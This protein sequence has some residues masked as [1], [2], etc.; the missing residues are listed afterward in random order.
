MNEVAVEIKCKFSLTRYNNKKTYIKIA[1]RVN[2]ITRL[3]TLHNIDITLNSYSIFEKRS[4]LNKLFLKR[5]V[6]TQG[7][8]RRAELSFVLGT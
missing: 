7:T 1:E 4:L 2:R 3:S 5:R 8:R 6:L